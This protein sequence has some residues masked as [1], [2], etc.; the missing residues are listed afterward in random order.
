MKSVEHKIKEIAETGMRFDLERMMYFLDH[1][2]HPEKK[3]RVIHIGGTNGKGS[4][5]NF[6]RFMLQANGYCVGTFTSPYLIHFH[7]QI[8]VNGQGISEKDLDILLKKLEPV[9][10]KMKKKEM[11]GPT[12]FEILTMMAFL[13]FAEMVKTDYCIFEVGLGGKTDS[14]NV[15][16]PILTMIT[17]ISYE[18]TQFLGHTLT[19]IATEKGGIMKPNIPFLTTVSEQEPKE[20]L[21]QMAKKNQVPWRFISVHKDCTYKLENGEIIFE[22][23]ESYPFDG[24][25]SI[26]MLGVHQVQNALLALYAL[27]RLYQEE[28]LNLSK[29]KMQEGLIKAKWPGRME[30]FNQPFPFIL[31]GSHN[32]EGIAQLK[33]ALA[34][35]FPNK[36]KKILFA[37]SAD[38]A[39]QEMLCKLMQISDEI[40]M[41]TFSHFRSISKAQVDLLAESFPLSY[42]ENW[43]KWITELEIKENEML[44][45]T[46]SL[47]FISEVRNFFEPF[48]RRE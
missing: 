1:F 45:I 18:H 3:I 37:A 42:I 17:T 46:G 14:T 32:I 20:V 47:Y 13:Y 9:I 48:Q 26:R 4:T 28:K 11:G 29:K 44:V 15:V 12:E 34:I 25:F 27:Q 24:P 22:T 2:H 6:L 21:Y 8:A 43:R 40:Y 31:D 39:H 7:E 30:S 23:K 5:L 19:E 36:K 41:T 16:H 38:K 10:L 33:E 35:H